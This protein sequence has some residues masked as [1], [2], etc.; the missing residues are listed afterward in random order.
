MF[1]T[2]VTEGATLSRK[3]LIEALQASLQRL[4]LQYVDLVV[5]NR[6][7]G[8]CPMEEIV[9]TMHWLVERGL[10]LY[11]GTSR[12]SAAH[13][14]EAF[15]VARQFN[16]VPPACEQM[17]Y[18]MGSSRRKCETAMNE[19]YHRLGVGVLS[20]SVSSLDADPGIAFINRKSIPEYQ[21]F[22][23]LGPPEANQAE[24]TT[25]RPV[26]VA[27]AN[28]AT[29]GA[30]GVNGGAGEPSSADTASRTG[31][32]VS[33]TPELSSADN[34]AIAADQR[35]LSG[36]SM[37]LSRKSSQMEKKKMSSVERQLLE[38][39]NL[40]VE[41]LNDD[42]RLQV[43]NDR[44]QIDRLSV[45]RLSASSALSTP[46]K[47]PSASRR[48][49]VD[50]TLSG[51]S[52]ITGGFDRAG[53]VCGSEPGK[54]QSETDASRDRMARFEALCTRLGCDQAQFS[55]GNA[56]KY[57]SSSIANNFSFH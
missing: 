35:K 27:E 26:S 10:A 12:W 55:I 25:D 23:I 32:A 51:A 11:W 39:A 20:W 43:I 9:R 2:H 5:V 48:R 7:D 47:S 44:L 53:S 22:G 30:T 13:L 24:T 19:L 52:V 29:A 31:N 56:I 49:P 36:V 50:R 41:R 38:T 4:Q 6:L 8:R 40:N 1:F 16:C 28:S 21:V 17:E 42:H 45:D 46:D 57:F 18:A 54:N 34:S 3:F 33:R 15:S 37:K 14:A